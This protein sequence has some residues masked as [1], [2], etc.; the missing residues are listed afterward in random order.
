MAE[1]QEKT[2]QATP[3]KRQKAREEGRVARSR[4][5]SSMLSMGGV[6][7]I[8]FFMGHTT[9]QNIMDLTR[10]GLSLP[11]V[12]GP[13]DVMIDLSAKGL[14]ILL[15]FMAIAVLMGISGNVIQG[16][17]VIKPLKIEVE[18]LNPLEGIKRMISGQAALEF[19]KGLVKFIVGALLLYFVVKKKMPAILE[20]MA[21]DVRTLSVS[22]SD[23]LLYAIKIG[24]ICFFL[25]SIL[26]Y[27][28]ER[29]KHERSLRMSKEEVKEVQVNGG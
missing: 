26:D 11:H 16:G 9:I 23:M 21:M 7:L 17:F 20:L 14:M 5:L 4:E 27:I 1:D 22:M 13:L 12:K 10:E 3:Q 25:I 8:I 29:W 28:N 6:V 18:K 2:Q 19:L 15:P 24:F